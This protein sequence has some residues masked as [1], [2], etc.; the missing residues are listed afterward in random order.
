MHDYTDKSRGVRLQKALA[1]AGV[2][3]RRDCEALIE[4]G[5]VRVNGQLVKTLPA[6]VDAA[7]DRLEVD[8][9]L[10]ARSRAARSGKKTAG[11][12]Y[13]LLHKPRRVVSTVEDEPGKDR[14]TVVDL[15]DHP[16]A[17]RLYPVGRLDADSTGLILLTDDGDLTH[18]LTH[19]RFGV[20]KRYLVS[21]KGRLEARDLERLK[22]GLV[23]ADR[24]AL[25]KHGPTRSG[26]AAKRASFER[27][28]IVR[29]ETDRA[30]GDR[31]TLSVTLTEGQNREIRRMLAQLGFKVRKLKRT[32]LGPLQLKG[33]SPGQ[34]RPLTPAEVKALRKATR[35]RG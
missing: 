23:L 24:K 3:S 15:V 26:G 25:E 19:P 35:T 30:R 18:R 5:R 32:A 8:G 2:A 4:A 29:H 14:T 6:W 21:V 34:W 27:V 33:L 12:H 7:V 17:A 13:V 9:E 28:R 11:K 1:E 31:T 10:V 22:Q 16:G 20:T